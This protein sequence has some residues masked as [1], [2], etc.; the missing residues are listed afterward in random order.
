MVLYWKKTY[1]YKALI[2]NEIKVDLTE[3]CWIDGL[4]HKVRINVKA[5]DEIFSY[6]DS[7]S[8]EDR[9]IFD[10][11]MID[12]ITSLNNFWKQSQYYNNLDIDNIHRKKFTWVMDN[13]LYVDSAEY[14]P[15]EVYSDI[16]P[17]LGH[18]FILHILLSLGKFETELDLTVQNSLRDS[19]QYAKLIGPQRDMISLKQYSSKLLKTYIVE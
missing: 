16:K 7:T 15:V 11:R 3:S 6:F 8:N 10:I 5:F 14:L 9:N 19:L 2:E 12:F 13:L 17:K 4:A 1:G 18:Q